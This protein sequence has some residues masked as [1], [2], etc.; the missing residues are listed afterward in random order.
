[1]QPQSSLNSVRQLTAV[2]VSNVAH[3]EETSLPSGLFFL[4]HQKARTQWHQG[5]S[6][7]H[8][9][10]APELDLI[11]NDSFLF[12]FLIQATLSGLGISSDPTLLQLL[13]L[14]PCYHPRM[15][16]ISVCVSEGILWGCLRLDLPCPSSQILCISLGDPEVSSPSTGTQHSMVVGRMEKLAL[17]PLSVSTWI[18]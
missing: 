17:G 2:D 12:L 5:L 15:W 7:T 3:R 11:S 9:W 16:N 14:V 10:F 18:G 13:A 6:K 4:T 8:G 1:M